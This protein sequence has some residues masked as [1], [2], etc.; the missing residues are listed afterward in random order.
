MYY[1]GTASAAV[2]VVVKFLVFVAGQIHYTG[3]N[4]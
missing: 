2:I 3:V 4:V 1:L